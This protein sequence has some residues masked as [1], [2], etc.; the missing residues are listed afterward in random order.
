MNIL[1]KAFFIA[2]VAY[3][4]PI[5]TVVHLVLIVTMLDMLTGITAS[6]KKA[7][8]WKEVTFPFKMNL[9]IA[10]VKSHIMG[11]SIIKIL[12]Y[13]TAILV[14][15]GIENILISPTSILLTKCVA[16]VIVLTEVASLFEN[17]GVICNEQS[18]FLKIFNILS[19]KLNGNKV[20][21]NLDYKS[22]TNTE[23]LPKE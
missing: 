10:G 17:L 16:G 4:S 3:F 5:A 2:T 13:L 20:I 6:I 11:R 18:L 12:A 21:E 14:T 23:G 19:T 1:I 22:D 15:Y 9:P 7:G 8:I